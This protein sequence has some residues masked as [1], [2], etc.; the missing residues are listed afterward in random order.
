MATMLSIHDRR[1]LTAVNSGASSL[2]FVGSGFIVLCYSLFRELRKFS[3]KLVFYLSLSVIFLSGFPE[4]QHLHLVSISSQ[5]VFTVQKSYGM[6]LGIYETCL[7]PLLLSYFAIFLC[8]TSESDLML[9]GLQILPSFSVSL[10][11]SHF[12]LHLSFGRCRTCFAVSLTWSGMLPPP[13][14]NFTCI[15]SFR[16][17]SILF[18]SRNWGIIALYKNKI[19]FII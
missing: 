12:S 19:I 16:F 18:Y 3:F 7:V 14:I 11:F 17:C 15:F 1:I 10:R 2:S 6:E 9:C 5:Y 8:K 13:A 4:Y